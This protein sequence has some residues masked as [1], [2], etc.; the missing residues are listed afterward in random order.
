MSI[1]VLAEKPSVARDL[2]RVIGAAGRAEGYLHGKGYVVTWAL[3]HLVALAEPHEI[4]PA[5][6]GWRWDG[7]PMLPKEWPLDVLPKTRGQFAV[8]KKLLN[9]KE[10]ELVVAATDAGREGEL[11]FR[12][13]YEKAGC[14]KPVQRLWLS[15][16]TPEAIEKAFQGLRPGAD[17]EPLAAAARGRSRADWLVGM[18]LTRAYTLGHREGT[19]GRAVLSVGRVQTPTLAILAE[20]DRAIAEFVPE[21]Y[22]EVVAEF[23][24]DRQ[25]EA[26]AET[27]RG[28]WFRGDDEK[29]TR[30]PPDGEEAER[31]AERVRG[32]A[33]VLESLRRET[34]RRPPPLLYDLTELQRDANRLF[35]FTAK[36]TLDLAQDLYEKRKLLSYPRTDSRHLSTDVAGTLG[37]IVGVISGP[38][39]GL[40]APGTGERPLG[41]RF[42]DDAK[43]T[44]HHALLP[45]ATAPVGLDL[46]SDEGRIYD[47]VCRRLL[48]AWHGDHVVSVATV[49]TRVDS[50][51]AADR[52]RSSGA[53]VEQVGWRALEVV[54]P[55]RKGARKTEEE[56]E[57]QVLPPG[58][59]EGQRQQ[60]VGAEAVAKRTRPPKPHTEASL[61]TAMESAGKALE[62]RELSEAMKERGL[63]TPATRAAIIETLLDR[64]YLSREGKALRVTERGFRL[65]ELVDERVK[66]PALTGEWERRLREIERGQGDLGVFL[67]GIEAYVREVVEGVRGSGRGGAERR[68]PRSPR[69]QEPEPGALG[70]QADPPVARPAGRV[71]APAGTGSLPGNPPRPPSAPAPGAGSLLDLLRDVFRFPAF[72]PYQEAVCRSVAAGRDGLLVM[73]TGSGKSLCYQLPALARGGTALVVSP[74]IALMEDQVAKLQEVGVAAERIHSGRDRLSSREVCHRYLAGEL[75]FLFIAPERLGVPGFPEMLGKRPLALVAVDEAHCISQWGH[76]FRPDYRMLKDRLPAILSR[77]APVLALTATATP[78]VQ[79]D[80]V[81]QLGIRGAER[82]IHGFRRTNIAVEAAEVPPGDRPDVVLEALADPGR[83]PAIVYAPTRK[84]A[85]ALAARLGERFRA[86]AYHAGMGAAERDRVQTAFLSGRLD[87][88][89]A[90]IAFGMGIDKADVRTV[91]H[92]ALPSSIEGYYQ[93]IGRAGRD[94]APSRALLLHSYGDRR[95]HEFFLERDYPDPAVLGRLFGLLGAEK[96]PKE[97]LRARSR[98][99]EESFAAALDKLWIHGGAVVD[100]EETVRRGREG[101]RASYETQ[102]E[103]RIAQLERVARFAELPAC[104]MLQLVRHF[105]D[106]EDSG[107]PCGQ[108]DACAPASRLVQ[109]GGAPDADE[110]GQLRRLLGALASGERLAVGRVFRDAFE[111]T[112]DRR[113]FEVLLSALARAGL[114][115]LTEDSFVKEG[116]AVAFRRASLTAEGRR[117]LRSEE[118]L[119]RVRLPAPPSGRE[120]KR[121]AKGRAGPKAGAR[122]QLEAGEAMDAALA[123]A[124]KAWR[125]EEARRRRVPAF[126][127]LTDRVLLAVAAARPATEAE[128]L[129]VPGFGPRLL[130]RYG[131]PILELCR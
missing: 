112:E 12:Y 21:D 83:R 43:V 62:D 117:T 63:G 78:L 102:R 114:V 64:A 127:I 17:F 109:L 11:I 32:G 10:T 100:P 38:Y 90:T 31:I 58:L 14:R 55:R 105:G 91:I 126:R 41:R 69:A 121:A 65:I 51:G 22:R 29:A 125:L 79:D 56:P 50:R 93:E 87:A 130:A 129:D 26:P 2:A 68:P 48:S 106:Q 28:T 95:T 30:L 108:C 84:H 34:K 35:G 89:V 101:W 96:Q 92:A 71:Q 76:D 66:S 110:L 72:R 119:G 6:K 118:A 80:I 47:L 42:V 116:K 123:A 85:E 128:L 70:P 81:E 36:K 39:R 103:H 107:E 33:A 113:R 122:R 86:A 75:D 97:E 73:P 124:L 44:D 111:G 25:E 1:V 131:R 77:S 99:D 15:S 24:V 23:A 52:F 9:A 7:L 13:V 46:A 59:S 18:N 88:I 104:R 120:K 115:Q 61:L 45:T 19:D 57:D 8:V 67:E 82:F 40:L 27:Y 54:A 4:D 53:S 98:L 5:W 94:G 3:G 49:I 16:L 60:V 37:A 20:R 74:L